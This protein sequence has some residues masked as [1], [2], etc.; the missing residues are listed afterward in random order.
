[1]I[2]LRG[3]A[4][5]VVGVGL[6][7]AVLSFPGAVATYAMP[8][9]VQEQTARLHAPVGVRLAEPIQD[10]KRE[11]PDAIRQKEPVVKAPSS[12]QP[13]IVQMSTPR[14]IKAAPQHSGSSWIHGDEPPTDT[15]TLVNVRT[16]GGGTFAL[17]VAEKEMFGLHNETRKEYGL[18]PLCLSPVLTKAARARSQDMLNRDYFSHYTP[19]GVTVIDQLKRKGYYSQEPSDYHI[20]GENIAMGGDGSDQDTPE[21]LF[22]EL[23]HSEGHRENILRGDF[24][25]V[26]V[27]AR[28]GTYQDYVDISTIYTTVFG[29][30]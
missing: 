14:A 21:H 3:G 10:F 7:L 4:L 13:L 23:M 17:N 16:C 15:S 8:Y 29:G 19:G 5:L 20:L 12:A 27:G 1:M 9:D 24:D 6:L 11:P 18:G 30:R 25:E 28:S 26:G 2:R 22:T